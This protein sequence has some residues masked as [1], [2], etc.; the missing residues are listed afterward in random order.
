MKIVFFV[1]FFF[2]IRCGFNNFK[3]KGDFVLI[4]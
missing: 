1:N 4:F 3:V 2:G